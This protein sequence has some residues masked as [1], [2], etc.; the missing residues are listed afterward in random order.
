MLWLL[1]F[2]FPFQLFPKR[3][4]KKDGDL[5][6]SSESLVQPSV[7]ALAQA[8]VQALGS[9]ATFQNGKGQQDENQ[10]NES[11]YD[12][13]QH[14]KSQHDN[15][16]HDNSQHDESQHDKSQYDETDHQE[17]QKE[18]DAKL[19]SVSGVVTITLLEGRNLLPMDTNGFSDPYVKFK[20]GQA[21][22]KSRVRIINLIVMLENFDIP[23]PG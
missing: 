23:C 1:A 11:Q 19:K 16:Q 6:G 7:E 4:N 2:C 5:T 17:K 3:K 10:D 12:E 22:Y 13:S 18:K 8:S 14:D 15:S 20:L 21:K 9:P